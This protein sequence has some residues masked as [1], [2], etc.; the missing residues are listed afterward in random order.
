MLWT[1]RDL[2]EECTGENG[3]RQWIIHV[4]LCYPTGFNGYL[5]DLLYD[6]KEFSQLTD[7]EIMRERAKQIAADPER[8]RKWNELQAAAVRTRKG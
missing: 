5:G 6:S 4:Y 3:S 7:R 1:P 8:D 2:P